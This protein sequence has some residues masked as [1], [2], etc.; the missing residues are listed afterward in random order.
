MT[1]QAPIYTP[2]DDSLLNCQPENLLA[3]FISRFNAMTEQLDGVSLALTMSEQKGEGM[4]RL[5]DDRKAQ[6][7]QLSDEL[8]ECQRENTSCRSMALDAEKIAQASIALQ[9]EH[10]KLKLAHKTLQQDYTQLKGGDNP[11]RLRAQLDKV[12]TKGRDKDKRIERLQKEIREYCQER[13]QAKMNV[14]EAID[15][16]RLLKQE[17]AHNSGAGLY[18]NGD[19][20]L[21]VW[22][23]VTTMQREDGSTFSGRSLLYL[24]Q[25]GRG[26]LLTYDPQSGTHLCAAPKGG[27]RPL[28]EM[29]EFANDW[30]F[31][32]N[33]QQE[34]DCRPDDMIPVN[35]NV[36]IKPA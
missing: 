34:G 17:L 19:H 9:T 8:T 18:H 13:D 11:A 1:E 14:K 10:A 21:I 29:L 31:K 20:H 26:G 15:K 22:P 36:D 3:A 28:A 32:V 4:Q 24:H 23:Q 33:M 30:L 12:K 27:L 16:I 25:S 5:L 6:L 2:S 7:T 35:Y